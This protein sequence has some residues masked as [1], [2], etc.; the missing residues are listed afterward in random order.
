M[1]FAVLSL[2]LY[3]ETKPFL[4]K[5][6]NVLAVVAQYAT[7]ITYGVALAIE[8][9]VVR[10]TKSVV[11]GA[12]LTATNLA[13]I[14][15][16]FC[17]CYAR[18]LGQRREWRQKKEH[19][20]ETIESAVGV[21]SIKLDAMLEKVQEKHVPP[22]HALVFWYCSLAE[23][24]AALLSGIPAFAS[25]PG[26][27][28]T[29]HR[30]HE[31]DELDVATFTKREAV[32]ACAVPWRHL[33]PLEPADSVIARSSSALCVIPAEVLTALRGSY[34]EDLVNAEPWHQGNVLLQ[35][36]QIVRAYRLVKEVDKQQKEVHIA[37]TDDHSSHLLKDQ[38][39]V[40]GLAANRETGSSKGSTLGN[41]MSQPPVMGLK[42]RRSFTPY[43]SIS[44]DQAMAPS[45]CLEFTDQMSHLRAVCKDKGWMPV[46]HFTD[47]SLLPFI[48]EKGFRATAKGHGDGGVYFSTLG[49]A[50]Y[51]LGTSLYEENIIVDC[52]GVKK[53]K[54][55]KGKGMLDLCLV[56]GADPKVLSQAPG[57]RRKEYDGN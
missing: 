48:R 10:G 1:L 47:V 45:T 40:Q 5:S 3:Y 27:V 18:Y 16:F 49:P 55:Y 8:V 43:R 13:L 26:V 19:Q 37:A 35:P 23:A 20:A 7:L 42:R 38:P 54:K 53:L 57:E 15:A 6:S 17:V 25:V 28:A 44:L 24:E 21:S 11:L 33:E 51:A 2:A 30:P 50:A 41:S 9:G 14:V 52:F 39:F 31:L 46:Y 56:Y 12:I 4:H 36:H 34:F 22:T 32:L 29:L